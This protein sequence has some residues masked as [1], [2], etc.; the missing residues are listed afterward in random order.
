[1]ESSLVG[2]VICDCDID[3]SI[4]SPHASRSFPSSLC[5]A[6][7]FDLFHSHCIHLFNSFVYL[8]LSTANTFVGSCL[9]CIPSDKATTTKRVA[10]INNININNYTASTFRFNQHKFHLNGTSKWEWQTEVNLSNRLHCHNALRF[11]LFLRALPK[12]MCDASSTHVRAHVLTIHDLWR[13]KEI[14]LELC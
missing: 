8:G 10:I 6:L 13:T 7:C 11:Q 1:M 9:S 3:K 5:Q 2:W 14:Y 12:C 4:F